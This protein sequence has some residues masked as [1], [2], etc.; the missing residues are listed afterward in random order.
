MLSILE[1]MNRVP[2]FS[3]DD[4]GQSVT[5]WIRSMLLVC[6]DFCDTVIVTRC[7]LRGSARAWAMGQRF[8][9]DLSFIDFALM[10]S[11]RFPAGKE[12]EVGKHGPREESV[13]KRGESTPRDPFYVPPIVEPLNDGDAACGEYAPKPTEER[14]VPTSKR[15]AE[16]LEV[17]AKRWMPEIYAPT[18]RKPT[19]PSKII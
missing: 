6:P 5:S 19:R 18:Q 7:I 8:P 9:P 2:T 4:D 16:P 14:Y 1:N 15:P 13:A 17:S 12:K 3:G 10:L 11:R